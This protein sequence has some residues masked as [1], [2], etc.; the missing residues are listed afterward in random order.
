MASFLKE[1][2]RNFPEFTVED[3]VNL[4]DGIRIGH[5]Q[6][7]VTRLIAGVTVV[8]QPVLMTSTVKGISLS[9]VRGSTAR[10]GIG[11]SHC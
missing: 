11:N 6:T 10:S 8:C 1:M 4:P 7:Q 2:S 9:T 3:H 5:A